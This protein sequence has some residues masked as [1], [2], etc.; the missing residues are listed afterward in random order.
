MTDPNDPLKDGLTPPDYD[1]Y[2][3]VPDSG[4]NDPEETV[5]PK[6]EPNAGESPLG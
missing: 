4:E 2:G 3:D 6:D 5:E 1:E